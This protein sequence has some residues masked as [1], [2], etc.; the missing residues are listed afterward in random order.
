[1]NRNQ[2]YQLNALY[3]PYA[4]VTHSEQLL[5]SSLY[6]D[7]IYVLEPNF[8]QPPIA[9]TEMQIPSSESMHALVKSG[10]VKPIGPHFLGINKSP[11]EN[12]SILD[13]ENIPL[14]LESIRADLEDEEL[15]ALTERYGYTA[16]SIPSGQQLFWNG[17]GLL[18]ETSKKQ[19]APRIE[20]FTDRVR[21]YRNFLDSLGYSNLQVHE[22]TMS[23]M[24]IDSGDLEVQVPFLE[25]ESLMVTVALLAC[26]ELN[27]Y[28]LTDE[29]IHHEFLCVKLSNPKTKSVVKDFIHTLH[30]SIKETELA[31]KGIQL[32]L[33]RL[34]E[35]SAEKVLA[36]RKKCSN[37]LERYRISMGKL[38][39]TIENNVWSPE[40]YSEVNKIIDTEI[41]PAIAELE[42]TFITRAKEFEVK[43]VDDVIK[44]SP[45]PLLSTLALG[46][47][48][49]WMLA[50][51]AGLIFLK[52]FMDY[53]I[54]K[55]AMKKN[56]L[57]F[58]LDIAT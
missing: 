32:Y 42:D 29:R 30:S 35:L 13:Q 21:Y 34:K 1:M 4:D 24:R 41:K 5:L 3:Y 28:P 46:F 36:I 55:N 12:H 23:R 8:F 6:F 56:G 52:D 18:L 49:E 51:S 15:R 37:S 9:R 43:L 16:W 10:V 58:L 54:K 47:P 22:R 17:L 25:A 11:F 14:I 38:K 19:L 7:N 45:V 31:I 48:L 26:S 44:L 40:L 57:F 20:V 39:H 50:A 33:P 2:A 53:K 27:L